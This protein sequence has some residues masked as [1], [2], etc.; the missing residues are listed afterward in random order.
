MNLLLYHSSGCNPPLGSLAEA[1][2][3]GGGWELGVGWGG[4]NSLILG[5]PDSHPSPYSHLEQYS[6]TSGVTQGSLEVA[7][8]WTM[9]C[10]FLCAT[11]CVICVRLGMCVYTLCHLANTGYSHTC[12][13]AW[14]GWRCS[15]STCVTGS[16][17][18]HFPASGCPDYCYKIFAKSVFPLR[19]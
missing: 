13:G 1:S 7:M 8:L 19:Q 16:W 18:V 2:L 6:V 11:V 10:V 15:Q 14:V 5:D 12:S 9:M 17:S 4:E 3:A